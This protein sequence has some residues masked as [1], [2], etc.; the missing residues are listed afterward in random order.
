MSEQ[1]VDFC[2]DKVQ[3]QLREEHEFSWL[4]ELGEVFSVFYQQDSG[5]LSFGVEKDGKKRFVKYAGARTLEYKGNPQEAI[6]RLKEAIHLYEELEHPY[7]I[8]I[9]EHFEVKNGYVAVFEWFEG[10]C[11]H[12]HWNFPPP[13]KYTHPDSPYYKFRKMPLEKRY[14]ALDSIYKFHAHVEKKG[15]VA[16]D[17]YDGSILY[18]FDRNE[19]KIC[20]IDLYHK[21]PYINTIGR[22]W[23]SSKIMSPEEF[24]MGASIDER[25]NVFNMGA[26][27]FI[28]L[29]GERDR[30]FEKWEG[31]KD[32]F[33]I[34]TKAINPDR[35][36]RFKSVSE[37]YSI[38][39]EYISNR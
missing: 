27:S 32:L 24:I 8:K 22:M 12:S 29:G 16:I 37:L 26:M 34:V 9:E 36:Q 30:A 19:T 33:E 3:F 21:K 2:I 11:L 18:D 10:E 5:N 13:H 7:L 35:E 20:D 1:T 38:W 14:K 39:C 15:Y 23:G 6:T 25:S 4:K 17:F 28:L 31:D